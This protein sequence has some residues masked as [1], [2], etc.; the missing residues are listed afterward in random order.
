MLLFPGSLYHS[1]CGIVEINFVLIAV[2]VFDVHELV[3]FS[4]FNHSR[5]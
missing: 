4:I 2:V 3:Q 5:T 1:V